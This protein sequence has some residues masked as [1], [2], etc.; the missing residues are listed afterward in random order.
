[1][2]LTSALAVIALV[3]GAAAVPQH[4]YLVSTDKM[5]RKKAR[6]YCHAKGKAAG[7]KSWLAVMSDHNLKE[8]KDKLIKENAKAVLVHKHWNKDFDFPIVVLDKHNKP[9][10]VEGDH[11]RN[12]RV[13]CQRLIAKESTTEEDSESSNYDDRDD[14]DSSIDDRK[15]RRKSRRRKHEPYSRRSSRRRSS[16]RRTSHRNDFRF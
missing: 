1:M 8:A 12:Y 15:S 5:S 14:D 11:N 16:K 10:V 2:L 7:V 9:K 4:D 13:L 3:C 6:E